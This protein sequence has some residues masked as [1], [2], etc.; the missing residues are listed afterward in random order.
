MAVDV[1]STLMTPPILQVKGLSR[2]FG[3]FQAVK[4]VELEIS[5]GE[6]VIL[7]GPSS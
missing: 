6:I 1:Y 5:A 3:E 4:P 2:S 7:T